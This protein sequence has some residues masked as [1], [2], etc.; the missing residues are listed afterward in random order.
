MLTNDDKHKGLKSSGVIL[1]WNL[2]STQI[3]RIQFWLL[4]K[5]D[6][7]NHIE[8]SKPRGPTTLKHLWKALQKITRLIGF[9]TLKYVSCCHSRMLSPFN[10]TETYWKIFKSPISFVL[11]IFSVTLVFSVIFSIIS[12]SGWTQISPYT[13][14]RMIMTLNITIF[15]HSS[16][17]LIYLSIHKMNF[18]ILR[19]WNS[20]SQVEVNH[21]VEWRFLNYAFCYHA[22]LT[23]VFD[24]DYHHDRH[25]PPIFI[26]LWHLCSSMA[27]L[28]LF[29]FCPKMSAIFFPNC[30]KYLTTSHN[31][32]WFKLQN[33][34]MISSE[35]QKEKNV[36]STGHMLHQVSVQ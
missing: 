22:T 9:Y 23:W 28:L 34:C 35:T 19:A 20:S 11:S 18:A 6:T 36:F 4:W 16:L 13:W 26:T 33:T 15:L 31:S 32:I 7:E 8:K 5:Y 21:V 2:M 27:H 12:H 24:K 14:G 17:N 25:T 1:V 29:F 30:V 3:S 10:P